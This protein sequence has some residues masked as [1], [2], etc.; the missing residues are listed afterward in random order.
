MFYRKVNRFYVKNKK[1]LFPFRPYKECNKVYSFYRC[2]G[3]FDCS[4]KLLFS[5]FFVL[6]ARNNKYQIRSTL[7]GSIFDFIHF[8]IRKHESFFFFF[9]LLFHI[10]ILHNKIFR[11]FSRSYQHRQYDVENTRVLMW[12]NAKPFQIPSNVLNKKKVI[13]KCVINIL[14]Q[15]RKTKYKC[16]PLS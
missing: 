13:W 14:R 8:F 10:A 11:Y 1:K 16:K 5:F 9:L 6:Q 2:F 4:V 12:R 15:R 3:Y 7:G